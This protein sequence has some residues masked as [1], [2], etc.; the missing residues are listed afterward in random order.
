MTRFF[1]ILFLCLASA[2]AL[3]AQQDAHYTQFMFNKLYFNP[4]Y[5]GAKEALS[6]SAIYRQQW[7]G[8]PGAPRTAM[9]NLHAPVLNNRVGLGLS[10]SNDQIGLTSFWN[11]E[12][13]YSYRIPMGED[14]VLSLGLRSSLYFMQVRWDRASPTQT[15]DGSIPGGEAS[16][17]LPNF[18]AGAYYE[19]SIFYVGLATPRL[20]RNKIDF[21][22]T[23]QTAIEPRLERHIFL[24]G[25]LVINLSENVK[26]QPNVMFKYVRN[27]PF[28]M[29]LNA[30][31]VFHERF[32]AGITYRL[33]DSVDGM[34]QF[35]AT[36]Q[37]MLGMAYDY[38]ISR[39]QRFNA[40]SIEVFI[41]YTFSAPDNLRM[42]NPRF[43]NTF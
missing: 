34:L 38:T 15:M 13:S 2:F 9:L 12:G 4:A 25:G 19:N 6:V 33:G 7:L 30:S 42:T 16:K 37:L 41:E 8:M 18:G 43:F 14:G 26:F 5:A 27:S 24:T 21:V 1:T 3:K 31:F 32:L 17:V 11:V 20:F 29:D 10:I 35:K 28:D 40:G 23:N 36:P 22:E 39:L